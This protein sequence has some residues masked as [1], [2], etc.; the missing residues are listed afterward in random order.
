MLTRTA[1]ETAIL[2]REFDAVLL[3]RQKNQER[4]DL[5][6]NRPVGRGFDLFNYDYPELNGGASIEQASGITFVTELYSTSDYRKIWAIE[7][8]SFNKNTATELIEEQAAMVAAQMKEDG[9][10][11]P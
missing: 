1:L 7:S 11:A 9:I 3:T 10:V 6:A 5:V 8:L 2:S 4:E